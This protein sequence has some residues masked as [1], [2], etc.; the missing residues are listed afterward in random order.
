M[1]QYTKFWK[2]KGYLGAFQIFACQSEALVFA[3][4]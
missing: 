4:M 3:T 2:T 1:V